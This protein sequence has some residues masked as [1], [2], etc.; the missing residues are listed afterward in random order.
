MFRTVRPF[1]ALLAPATL[2]LPVPAAAQGAAFYRQQLASALRDLD[3]ISYEL[4]SLQDQLH[5][6]TDRAQGC[7]LLKSKVYELQRGQV[8]AE[9]V[10]GYAAQLGEDELHRAAVDQ[11]NAFL[12]N[13]RMSEQD[14]ARNNCG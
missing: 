1:T 11:H 5:G 13:R 7:R 4:N 3:K 8:Q 10:A 14:L 9:K 6:V 12:E 2:A